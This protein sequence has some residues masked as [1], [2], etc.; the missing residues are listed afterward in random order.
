MVVSEPGACA[1]KGK[2]REKDEEGAVQ[3]HSIL[4]PRKGESIQCTPCSSSSPQW[5]ICGNPR[6]ISVR[7]VNCVPSVLTIK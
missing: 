2:H 3:P 4:A 7:Q 6:T 5:Q 1:G